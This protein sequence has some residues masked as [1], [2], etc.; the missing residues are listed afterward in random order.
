MDYAPSN[1][2]LLPHM[3]NDDED[4]LQ[5]LD[6]GEHMFGMLVSSS[7]EDL[8]A[9][10]N[11]TEEP[12]SLSWNLSS[13]EDIEDVISRSIGPPSLEALPQHPS[14]IVEGCCPSFADLN[15]LDASKDE[16]IVD[17]GD[18]NDSTTDTGRL[19][20]PTEDDDAMSQ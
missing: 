16:T 11:N 6:A 18:E 2:Q 10:L 1:H 15:I 14:N 5:V 19:T 3:E 4:Y 13:T 9:Y 20:P 8:Y 7:D 17:R 12:L